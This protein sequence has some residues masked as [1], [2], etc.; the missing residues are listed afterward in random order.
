MSAYFDFNAG[1]PL[2]P[3]A[4]AAMQRA[5]ELLQSGGNPS[6][7]HAEGRALRRC[8]ESAREA[9]ASLAGAD[10]EEVT[11]VSCVTEAAATVLADD[12]DD[13]FH[14]DL[15]HACIRNGVRGRGQKVPLR[16][17]GRIDSGRLAQMLAD[18]SGRRLLVLSAASHETGAVQEL[19]PLTG[20]AVRHDVRVYCDYAQALGR[21]PVS[22]HD[23]GVDYGGLSSSKL[24]GPSGVAA[25]LAR[26][27]R[28]IPAL[29]V[30]GGQERRRRAGT[31][32]VIGIVGFGAAAE[33]AASADWRRTAE[34]RDRL[35]K[36]V[37]S[38]VPDAVIHGG[39]GKRLPNV[40]CLSIPGWRAESLVMALDLDGYAVGAGSACSAGSFE[41]MQALAGSGENAEAAIRVSFGSGTS[42]AEVE[43]LVRALAG[44][45]RRKQKRDRRAAA[46]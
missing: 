12:W 17:D 29:L 13:V 11:F 46:A 19:P 42:A 43:G 9:V 25:L 28:D 1:A 14:S 8:I 27:G 45:A 31:E 24:G 16:A 30:G 20:L 34:L 35:E 44:L 21:V 3:A 36:G 22:F 5:M 6:A 40:S 37:L 18:G 38:A 41:P 2:H 4:A 32:N 10:P 7:Q 15:D 23:S 26:S 39:D 33:A